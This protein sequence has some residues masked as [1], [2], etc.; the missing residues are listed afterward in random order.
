MDKIG[1]NK[2]T[3]CSEIYKRFIKQYIVKPEI[4]V[5][6][7]LIPSDKNHI[8]VIKQSFVD[9]NGTLTDKKI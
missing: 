2:L 6:S 8:V 4:L 1:A 5:I 3:K 7:T 9:K